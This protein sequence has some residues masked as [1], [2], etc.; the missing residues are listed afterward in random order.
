[1]TKPISKTKNTSLVWF[2][3]DLRTSDNTALWN[4]SQHGP[5]IAVFILTPEQWQS[6]DMADLKV[7]FIKRSLYSL[8]AELSTLGIPLLVRLCPDYSSVPD[9][10]ARMARETGSKKVFWNQEYLLNEIDRDNQTRSLLESEGIQCN[11]YED[12]L[13]IPPGQVKNG[14]GGMY[15]VFTPFYR[16]W[17]EQVKSFPPELLHLPKKQAAPS[18]KS[19]DIEECFDLAYRNLTIPSNPAIN[20]LWPAGEK[21]ARNRLDAFTNEDVGDYS[22]LR[23][24]PAMEGT[25]SLSP[26]LSIGA[27]SARQCLLS[28]EPGK[29]SEPWIRQ[30]AWRDFYNHLVCAYPEMVRGEPF[31]KK[32]N[33]IQWRPCGTDFQ[34]WAQ[35]MTG[36]PFVDAG[37]RQLIQT[38]WMH[39]R[40]RMITAMFLTKNLFIDWHF[41]EKHFMQ[42]LIDGDFALNNGGWQWSASTGTDAAPYFRIF[43]P[44]SQSQRFDPTG[45]YIRTYVPELKN[46]SDAALHNPLKLAK[47]KPQ[48]YPSLI[49]DL[50][51]S[52]ASAIEAFSSLTK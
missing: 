29:N 45:S 32:T 42:N 48:D 9:T 1:M 31:Q 35:G 51:I 25:S 22:T 39:N 47:E 18:I 43:N 34:A 52:R 40:L 30:L 33:H 7:D 13:I 44:F 21:A 14:S 15:K 12:S 36:Q 16:N 46:L 8:E 20:S 11:S 50:K 4:A 3:N 17:S 24:N 38:G 49:V 5:V 37:M 2:R 6:H 19:D 26:Y 41:G 28:A 23:D 27:I 10:L